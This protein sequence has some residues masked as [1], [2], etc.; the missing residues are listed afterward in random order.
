M[1]YPYG[2]HI[3]LYCPLTIKRWNHH[4]QVAY[5]HCQETRQLRSINIREVIIQIDKPLPIFRMKIKHPQPMKIKHP[6][7]KCCNCKHTILEHCALRKKLLQTQ[8]T[9]LSEEYARKNLINTSTEMHRY[10]PSKDHQQKTCSAM[11]N[12]H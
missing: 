2:V 8:E 9:T 3:N 7:P 11:C 10:T 6:Q 4:N 12:Q 1:L 5:R